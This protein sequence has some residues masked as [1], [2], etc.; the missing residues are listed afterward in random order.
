M[1]NDNF[2]C[3]TKKKSFIPQDPGLLQRPQGPSPQPPQKKSCP[4]LQK[5]KCGHP[6]SMLLLFL[7]TASL[8][9]NYTQIETSQVRQRHGHY[10]HLCS[11]RSLN[12]CAVLLQLSLELSYVT[13]GQPVRVVVH[14]WSVYTQLCIQQAACQSS[15]PIQVSLE[16]CC[17]LI[18]CLVGVAVCDWAIYNCAVFLFVSLYLCYPV[19]LQATLSEWL[20]A[21]G[22]CQHYQTLVTNGYETLEFI[23]D[24]TQEDMKEIGITK[25]G[26]H[27]SSLLLFSTTSL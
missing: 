12:S 10:L 26:R 18:S 6:T 22:L 17:A 20:S 7:P 21:I 11:Y 8:F 16:L 27:Y 3:F 23:K 4:T 15:C 9:W 1:T 5:P 13:I 24:I 25:L 19:F 2:G 14:Y